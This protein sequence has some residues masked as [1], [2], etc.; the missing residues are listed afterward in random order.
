MSISKSNNFSSLQC[1]LVMLLLSIAVFNIASHHDSHA[2]TT[3]CSKDLNPAITNNPN[4]STP[5]VANFALN[6]TKSGGLLSTH[7]T[8]CYSSDN[9]L[10]VKTSGKSVTKKQLSNLK[11]FDLQQIINKNVLD[12]NTYRPT[13]GSADYYN[14]TITILLNGS[15][16]RGSWT[17]ASPGVPTGLLEVRNEIERDSNP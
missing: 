7:D 11:A 3:S 1:V 17:D 4:N 8:T 13:P 5:G 2:L 14:Y 9:G 15:K 12:F 10:M 6:Y 16:Y